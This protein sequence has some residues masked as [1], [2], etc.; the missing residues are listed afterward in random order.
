VI[1]VTT[2]WSKVRDFVELTKPR[3]AVLVLLV[4]I[5]S[6]IAAQWGPASGW[7]LIHA[8]IGTCLVAASASAANQLLERDRDGRMHRTSDRPLPSGR[9]TAGQ[10]LAFAAVTL[11]AGGAWL[12]VFAGWQ[13]ALY[14]LVTWVLY[15]LVY[16]PL[17]TR[18]ASNTAVGAFAGAMPVFIGWSAG[19]GEFDVRAVSLF[20]ILLL[21]QFPHFMAIA[22]L[23]RHDYARGGY[24]MLPVVDPSGR[25]AGVQAV[26]AAVALVPVAVLPALSAPNWLGATYIVTVTVLGLAQLAIAFWFLLQTSDR[27]ARCLLRMSLVYMPLVLVQL[28]AIP[29][30]TA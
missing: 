2:A 5:A 9:I 4:V 18:V 23:Y 16:T 12:A 1:Y 28:I 22:W 21:W 13:A 6:G 19:G 8:I 20:M 25:R 15:V 24:Q 26:L 14:A 27:S 29:L 17:K 11:L 7:I 10:A 3:I 30:G